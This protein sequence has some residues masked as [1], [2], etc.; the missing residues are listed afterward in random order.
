MCVLREGEEGDRCMDKVSKGN[1]REEREGRGRK[2]GGRYG[3]PA[4]VQWLSILAFHFG[5]FRPPHFN[6]LFTVEINDG[7]QKISWGGGGGGRRKER[8]KDSRIGRGR[9]KRR[10]GRKGEK[11]EEGEEGEGRRGARDTD[12]NHL[13]EQA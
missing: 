12:S 7:A 8:R 11:E 5:E 9:R 10:E 3:G 4:C 1:G 2:G 13:T 6:P